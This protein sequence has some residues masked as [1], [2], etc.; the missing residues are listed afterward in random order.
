MIVDSNL[1]LSGTIVGNSVAGQTV[2][3]TGN[4]LSTNTA[5]LLTNRD[6]GEGQDLFVRSQITTTF[7]GLTAMEIQVIVADDAALTSNVTVIGSTGAIP[8]AQLTAGARFAA[9]VN[10]RLRSIG[11]R[12]FGVR[13]VITGT[14]TAG[15]VFSDLGDALQDGQKFYSSGFAVL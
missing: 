5:D 7:T 12:Y 1:I 13:Y 2:T 14:G 8:V 15:A 9:G 4:V 11:Q 6:V 3:G 10:P